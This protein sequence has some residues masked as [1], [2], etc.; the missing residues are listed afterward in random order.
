M[1]NKDQQQSK[2]TSKISRINNSINSMMYCVR[3]LEKF[4]SYNYLTS[5]NEDDLKVVLTR[6]QELED[7]IGK[8]SNKPQEEKTNT[9]LIKAV[10]KDRK[11]LVKK[12]LEEEIKNNIE[13]IE[14]HNSSDMTQTNTNPL[15]N[16]ARIDTNFER[17]IT[18]KEYHEEAKQRVKKLAFK[19][20]NRSF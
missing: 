18:S 10:G 16:R 11:L 8:I 4:R 1:K 13:T 9:P 3:T 15:K 17:N 20:V 7:S 12:P 19:P 2:L 6:M 14:R 5:L